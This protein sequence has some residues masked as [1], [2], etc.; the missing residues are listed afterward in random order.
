MFRLTNIQSGKQETLPNRDDLLSLV[1]EKSVW[2]EDRN[3][4]FTLQLEQLAEDGSIIDNMTL[5]LPL[6][7]IVEEALSSF[8]LKRLKKG[9]S[10]LPRRKNHEKYTNSKDVSEEEPR[11]EIEHGHRKLV[12]APVQEVKEPEQGHKLLISTSAQDVQGNRPLIPTG[13]Q[14]EKVEEIQKPMSNS[15]DL[16][17]HQEKVEKFE[18]VR[19]QLSKKE[20]NEKVPK[21]AIKPQINKSLN[22]LIW[23]LLT[24]LS[25]VS[26]VGTF[27]Y[28]K[29]QLQKI[30]QLDGRISL[31]ENKGKIEVVGR[32]FISNYYSGDTKNLNPFL[33]KNLKAEGVEVNS[34]YSVQSI[35]YESTKATK[36]G[37]AM[38]FVVVTKKQENQFKTVRL[39]LPFKANKQSRYGYVLTGQPKFSSFAE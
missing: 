11:E 19:T 32:Y 25:L 20:K 28:T 15:S 23:K 16:F 2:A 5:T 21:Q 24:L 6:Q 35:I 14:N 26:A 1:N 39:T 3:I 36:D 12:S 34:G 37:V 31:Q 10:F 13:L 9:F 8:G 18:Q 30:E 4:S 27:V 17:N 29:V 38:T 22:L 7:E 33:S